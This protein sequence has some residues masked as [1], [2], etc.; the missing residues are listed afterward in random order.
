MIALHSPAPILPTAR[1]TQ[2]FGRPETSCLTCVPIARSLPV[3]LLA[4]ASVSA[5]VPST[6]LNSPLFHP[7]FDRRT[8][9]SLLKNR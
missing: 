4:T 3:A 5:S 1:S 8:R 7:R 9:L 6:T 2:S